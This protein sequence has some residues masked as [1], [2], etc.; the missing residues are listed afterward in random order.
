[1]NYF[2][3]T[4]S[5]IIPHDNVVKNQKT[6]TKIVMAEI[7]LNYCNYASSLLSEKPETVKKGLYS[8]FMIEMSIIIS[9]MI[10]RIKSGSITRIKLL[11]SAIKARR[12]IK[13]TR[14]GISL[15]IK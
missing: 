6:E 8:N 13:V 11:R 1:M 7:S 9:P 5:N 12:K 4:Y 3:L 10:R 14:S 15:L 2:E